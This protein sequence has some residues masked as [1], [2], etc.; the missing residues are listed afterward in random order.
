MVRGQWAVR[1]ALLVGLL[2][3]MACTTPCDELAQKSCQEA[4]TESKSC[5]EVKEKVARASQEDQKY[6][7]MAL[8]L[9]KTLERSK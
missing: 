7:K 9:V 6:C 3:E 5:A 2:S 1:L 4:G 8:E